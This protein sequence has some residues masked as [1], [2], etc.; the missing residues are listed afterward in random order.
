MSYTERLQQEVGCRGHELEE[1]FSLECTGT[2]RETA[3]YTLKS[4]GCNR[5]AVCPGEQKVGGTW[6]KRVQGRN[7]DWISQ[8]KKAKMRVVG[9]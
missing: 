6:S 3:A 1:R 8:A 2:A 4:S 5:L 7:W 9:S